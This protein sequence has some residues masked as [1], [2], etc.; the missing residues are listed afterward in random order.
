MSENKEKV[1]KNLEEKGFKEDFPGFYSHEDGRVLEVIQEG[2]GFCRVV[3][4]NR[5]KIGFDHV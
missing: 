5:I 4:P 1:L 2:N 3:E